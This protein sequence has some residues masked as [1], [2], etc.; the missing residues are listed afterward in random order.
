MSTHTLTLELHRCYDG[1]DLDEVIKE[2]N[3]RLELIG[4]MSFTR[5]EATRKKIEDRT[6]TLGLSGG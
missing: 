4:G 6:L 3:E 2:I 1:D 5:P